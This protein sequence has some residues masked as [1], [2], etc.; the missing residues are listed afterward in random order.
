MLWTHARISLSLKDKIIAKIIRKYDGELITKNDPF[1]SLCKSIVGQQV[2]VASAEAVWRRLNIKIKQITPKNIGNL[3]EKELKS[4]G[5]SR[6]KIIYIKELANNFINKNFN[7]NKLKNMNDEDAI[8]YLSLNKGIGKWSSE[9]FLLFNQNRLNIFPI[10]DI[11]FLKGISKNY[12]I[13][14]PPNQKYLNLLRNRW[15]PYCSVGTWY[16]WRTVDPEIVQY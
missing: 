5:F 6:Q 14:H 7:L 3:S 9:M 16:I 12:K 10:Q 1:Y 11:G 15:N 13:Q 2:S 8:N 4:C